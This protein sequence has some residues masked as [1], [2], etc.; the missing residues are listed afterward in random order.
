MRPS[1]GGE[2]SDALALDGRGLTYDPASFSSLAFAFAKVICYVTH[3]HFS[4][5]PKR[6]TEWFGLGGGPRR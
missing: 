6:K 1:Q 3:I 5:S 2:F 4:F